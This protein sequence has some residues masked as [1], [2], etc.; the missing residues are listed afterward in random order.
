M[1]S[2]AFI[3]GVVPLRVAEG[4]G[5]VSRRTMGTAV[6]TGTDRLRNIAAFTITETQRWKE[7]KVGS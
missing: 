3:L 4:S 7:E 1:T 6:F 5:A 2:F